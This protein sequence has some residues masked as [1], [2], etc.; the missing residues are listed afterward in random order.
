MILVVE[1]NREYVAYEGRGLIY[2]PA[3]QVTDESSKPC[4]S[5]TGSVPHTTP[6]ALRHKASTPY[7]RAPRI[8]RV[9]DEDPSLRRYLQ[10]AKCASDRNYFRTIDGFVY[11]L[12][13]LPFQR[14]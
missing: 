10:T 6:E 2:S 7:I 9:R 3:V 4:A 13:C 14:S 11:S 5:S 12:Y 1:R 8:A